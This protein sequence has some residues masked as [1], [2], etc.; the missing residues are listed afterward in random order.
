MWFDNRFAALYALFMVTTWCAVCGIEIHVKASHAA[1]GWGKYCSSACKYAGQRKGKWVACEYCGELIYRR[2]AD[3][4]KSDSKKFFCSKNC[5]CAWE[6]ENVRC[7]V[8]APNWMAGQNVYRKL[9]KRTGLAE[10]CSN[11]E[12]KDKRVL[13]VHHKDRNRRNNSIENLEWLCR[14][15]HSI[16][17]SS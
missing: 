15:C 10:K 5:H 9:L 14:N 12:I 6:N 13:V 2:P 1:R 3:Y 16:V 7:G 8:N 11:C 17:H 4:K